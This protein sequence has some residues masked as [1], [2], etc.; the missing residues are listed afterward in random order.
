[1][2]K[3]FPADE[4]PRYLTCKY[5]T[6]QTNIQGP[7]STYNIFD[8]FS[9]QSVNV[10]YSIMSRRCIVLYIGET[11]RRLDERFSEHLRSV[12]NNPTGFPFAEHFNIASHSLEDIAVCVLKRCSCDNS[13]CMQQKMHLIFE[14]ST[15]WPR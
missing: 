6:S 5:I 7:N 12:R 15:R 14:M 9:C 1:M 8:Q 11:G 10:V 2:P 13:R 3:Y 4:R